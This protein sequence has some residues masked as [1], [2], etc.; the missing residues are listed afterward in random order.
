VPD[1]R[2]VKDDRDDR[3][4]ATRSGT[5]GAGNKEA[6][7]P[8]GEKEGEEAADEG[9]LEEGEQG[10]EVE[11]AVDAEV[12]ITR[13]VCIVELARRATTVNGYLHFQLEAGWWH[14]Q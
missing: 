12:D 6:A 13:V 2:S 5:K 3:A 9:E 14:R 4:R 10:V 11:V 1:D 7:E 8:G